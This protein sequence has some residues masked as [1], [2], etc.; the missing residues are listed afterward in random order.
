MS[1]LVKTVCDGTHVDRNIRSFKGAD[2]ML[3]NRSNK[4]IKITH[5][6]MVDIL[7]T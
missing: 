6:H 3:Q 1:F 2:N 7:N 5:Y 4:F